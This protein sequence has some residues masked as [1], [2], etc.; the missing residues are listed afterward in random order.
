MRAAVRADD[1]VGHGQIE[2]EA[3]A[4]KVERRFRS[5]LIAAIVWREPDGDTVP[6]VVVLGPAADTDGALD[7]LRTVDGGCE[8]AQRGLEQRTVATA[9]RRQACRAR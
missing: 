9:C 5:V 1:R 6:G 4:A 3:A 8:R 2:P 7:R